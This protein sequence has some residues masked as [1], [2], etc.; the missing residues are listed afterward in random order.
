MIKKF[1]ALLFFLLLLSIPTQLGKHFW[2][3]SSLILGRRIDYLSPTIYLTDI[4]W[5]FWVT[6]FIFINK[7]VIY[8]SLKNNWI[9]TLAVFIISLVLI[10]IAKNHVIAFFYV[11]RVLELIIFATLVI[12]K[13]P[14]KL[15]LFYPLAIGVIASV[16][17]ET[18][19]FFQQASLG[20][21]FKFLGERSI[22]LNTPSVAH[23][24]ANGKIYLRPYA[25]FPH[26]NVLAGYLLLL[27][28]VWYF[29]QIDKY[30][31][32]QYLLK[33][34]LLVLSILG[35][36]LTFSRVAWLGYILM[37]VCVYG[38]NIKTIRLFLSISI[39]LILEEIFLGRFVNLYQDTQPI[40]ERN[41]LISNAFD[42][43]NRSPVFGAGLGNF[44]PQLTSFQKPP[45]LFQ[46][47]HNFWLMI[48]AETGIAGLTSAV[49][50]FIKTIKKTLADK[51]YYLF[52]SLLL[53]LWLSWFDHYFYDIKQTQWL[54]GLIVSLVWL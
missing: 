10:F 23:L 50:F 32:L 35:I 29:W 45:Y 25:F 49:V 39:I 19:Q 36:F 14:T 41:L 9:K 37:W 13:K 1:E 26:P 34:I 42:I 4:L 27:Y 52:V 20:G 7:K 28:P 2:L 18:L 12:L 46:P 17:L 38:K 11:L 3:E 44:L 33:N 54:L 43:F 16:F 40:A 15:N 24:I 51:K 31:K 5:I 6:A 8:K 47:V 21:L 48:L 53:F 30:S 22:D